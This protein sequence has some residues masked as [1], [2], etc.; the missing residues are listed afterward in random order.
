MLVR[1]RVTTNSNTAPGHGGG[2]A[3]TQQQSQQ[4]QHPHEAPSPPV[5]RQ[6]V[7]KQIRL[8]ALEHDSGRDEA[9]AAAQ[10]SGPS[11]S[12]SVSVPPPS[13]LSAGLINEVQ[14]LMRV[15]ASRHPNICRYRDSFLVPAADAPTRSELLCIVMDYYAGGDLARKI[16]QR[17]RQQLAAAGAA[18]QNES[19]RSSNS[20]ISSVASTGIVPQPPPPPPL[21][22]LFSEDTVIDCLVQLALGQSRQTDASEQSRPE[23]FELR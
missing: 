4:Q 22:A 15:G 12:V 7:I 20:S 5:G 10:P 23:F 18:Q 21:L 14:V 2:D 17:L 8:A 9:G 19:L 6:F 3:A 1:A 16:R 11:V 13:P